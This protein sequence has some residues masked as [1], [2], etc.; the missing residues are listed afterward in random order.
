MCRRMRTWLVAA[1][2]ATSG[3]ILYAQAPQKPS[4]FTCTML[5]SNRTQEAGCYI[6]GS[7]TLDRL[8]AGPLFWHLYTYP[9]L[10]A[11][12]RAKGTSTGVAVESL[13]KEWLF[14]IAPADWHPASGNRISVIGPL[15]SFA[16]KRY[17]IRYLETVQP[18]GP[19]HSHTPVHRHP[20]VEAWYV[21]SGQHCMQT[22]NT[23]KLIHA[24]ETDVVPAGVPMM[25]TPG[26]AERHLTLVLFD[27][28]R[29]WMTRA[30]DWMPS[31]ACPK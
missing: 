7:E 2:I 15:P 27:A 21:V 28:D 12:K 25:L 30:P 26:G 3:T 22:P 10:D 1:V 16:A 9:T 5:A 19:L 31:T 8:P 23:T 20:G 11:A 14:K 18:P 17:E 24:G 4:P 6:V 29:P 13:G